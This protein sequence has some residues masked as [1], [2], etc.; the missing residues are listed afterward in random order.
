V[1]LRPQRLP[2]LA[3]LY[4]QGHDPSYASI[5]AWIISFLVSAIRSSVS[6]SG[7]APGA[8]GGGSSTGETVAEPASLVRGSG[9]GSGTL[10]SAV[11]VAAGFGAVDAS[12]ARGLESAAATDTVVGCV[13]AWHANSSNAASSNCTT[14]VA[15]GGH[16]K[17]CR[18]CITRRS[19]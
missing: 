4:G 2:L 7:A 19:T 6:G 10:L 16:V 1:V 9:G 11:V 3:M 13:G 15:R 5:D 8:A 17:R 14:T 12:E 18:I